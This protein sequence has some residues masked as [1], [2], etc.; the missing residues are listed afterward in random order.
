LV[1]S[2]FV[3]KGKIFRE[4]P[5]SYTRK[6]GKTCANRQTGLALFTKKVY[7]RCDK[8]VKLKV[9]PISAGQNNREMRLIARPE[10]GYCNVKQN[11]SECHHADEG[12]Q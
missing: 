11:V 10:G 7:S 4:K 3:L 2:L 6:Y 12:C 8:C 9:R 5:L 1:G